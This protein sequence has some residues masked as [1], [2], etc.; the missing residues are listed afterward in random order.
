MTPIFHWLLLHEV[1]EVQTPETSYR[2]FRLSI[3]Y[4]YLLLFM[5]LVDRN[6]PIRL[7]IL[8]QGLILPSLCYHRIKDEP[9]VRLIPWRSKT[10]P[11]HPSFLV[12][13]VRKSLVRPPPSR[14][15]TTPTG[16]VP[17]EPVYLFL[18]WASEG[19]P[20][21]NT[22][23]VKAHVLRKV[24][25]VTY[26]LYLLPWFGSVLVDLV[27]RRVQKVVFKLRKK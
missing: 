24:V 9:F 16:L 13:G 5:L 17:V 21:K 14:G 10:H 25:R 23:A 7:T 15:P 26:G 1:R 2:P 22:L 6:N 20:S 19:V 12:S 4:S 11:T 3:C 27:Q 8:L 18:S